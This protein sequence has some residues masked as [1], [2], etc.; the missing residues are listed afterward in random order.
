MDSNKIDTRCCEGIPNI[1]LHTQKQKW[2]NLYGH[3]S[4]EE[5]KKCQ[6][7]M[8]GLVTKRDKRQGEK[9]E[10]TPAKR[11]M[12]DRQIQFRF[13]LFAKCVVPV[14]YISFCKQMEVGLYLPVYRLSFRG[15]NS[16]VSPWRLSRFVT[17]LFKCCKRL[18]WGIGERK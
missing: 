10:L 3:T 9:I 8:K 15:G 11:S 18:Y 4:R 7:K 16:I 2:L 5:T 14:V 13:H 6:E 17:K 12:I 1:W